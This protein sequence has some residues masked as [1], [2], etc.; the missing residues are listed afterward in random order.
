[1]FKVDATNQVKSSG[2]DRNIHKKINAFRQNYYKAR[3]IHCY[4]CFIIYCYFSLT[5]SQPVHLFAYRKSVFWSQLVKQ[6][7]S[8]SYPHHSSF[9]SWKAQVSQGR[10]YLQKNE[11]VSF[12][13]KCV[14]CL[15]AIN[16]VTSVHR[17]K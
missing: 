3:F 9:T 8:Q 13:G 15:F 11:G 12:T 4:S 1:M 2:K 5:M 14:K 10:E 7:V 17:R 16:V 6:G